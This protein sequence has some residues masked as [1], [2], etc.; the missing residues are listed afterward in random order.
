MENFGLLW[1]RANVLKS[2]FLLQSSLAH[3]HL[4]DKEVQQLT[5]ALDALPADQ[6][7]D[8]AGQ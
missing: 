4:L 7:N 1:M 8:K 3:H 2:P 6:L 5:T